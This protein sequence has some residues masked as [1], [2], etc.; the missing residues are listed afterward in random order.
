MEAINLT[1][2]K[3]S[4]QVQSWSLHF[5][6]SWLGKCIIVTE[7]M[8][9]R[10][11]SV[12]FRQCNKTAFGSDSCDLMCCGRGYNPYTEKLVE[13]CHC[14]YHWCC[15]VTCKKCD[16]IVEKYVCKWVG[17]ADRPPSHRRLQ[18]NQSTTIPRGLSF[19]FSFSM[20]ISTWSGLFL[21]QY[22]FSIES[23]NRHSG[24]SALS[25]SKPGRGEWRQFM[26]RP[27]SSCV[28]SFSF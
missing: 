21:C 14:K 3:P 16:R 10:E 11:S 17:P 12:D 6:V 2:R 20:C 25:L 13:R 27:P 19:V 7:R 8:N 22:H 23:P 9:H 4:W 26:W 18:I 5:S 28:F 1:G 15:Y 24:V